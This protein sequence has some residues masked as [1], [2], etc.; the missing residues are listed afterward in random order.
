MKV[1]FEAKARGF[2]MYEADIKELFSKV[3]VFSVADLTQVISNRTYA[4]KFISAMVERK[5]V[6]RIRKDLYTY[7]DDPFLISTFILRPSYIS[8]I[9]A[10][11][12]HQMITQIPK[13]V[14]CCTSKPTKTYFFIERIGF[15]Q[16]KSFFGFEMKKY[17]G[18]DIPIATP[19]KALID[20]I[21]YT[22]ISVTEEAFEDIDPERM[23]IY[24]QQIKKS[25][26]IKRIGYLLETHE[27][28][29]F[30]ILKKYI[31]DKYIPLDPLAKHKGTKDRKWKMIV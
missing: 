12:Y 3:P 27:H 14:F 4:K 21:G 9:S 8:G 13:E 26:I 16:T 17:L 15:H 1:L 30:P 22:P 28:D 19:E 31:N 6:K 2:M 23:I 5:K 25:N 7:H 10:L 29:A 20:S 24:L 11:S 18:F